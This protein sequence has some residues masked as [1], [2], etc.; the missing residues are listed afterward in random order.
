MKFKKYT[1]FKVIV[2]KDRRSKAYKEAVEEHGY[3]WVVTEPEHLMAQEIKDNIEKNEVRLVRAHLNQGFDA[4]V[5]RLN[6]HSVSVRFECALQSSQLAGVV[7]D[8]K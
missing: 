7:V 4:V 5:Y 2:A 1:D 3:D 6:F 8:D